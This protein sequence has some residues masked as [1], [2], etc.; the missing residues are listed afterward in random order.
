MSYGQWKTKYQKKA[1][2]EQAAKAAKKSVKKPETKSTTKIVQQVAASGLSN[3]CCTPA[4][5]VASKAMTAS[6]TKPL[7]AE[8]MNDAD[9]VD[10]KLPPGTTIR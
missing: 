9:P 7:G 6:A 8:V 10:V 1:T 4:E 3:V 2:P 5:E